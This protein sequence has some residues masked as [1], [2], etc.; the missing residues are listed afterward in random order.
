MKELKSILYYYNFYYKYIRE[1]TNIYNWTLLSSKTNKFGNE[2]RYIIKDE[3]I[4]FL[5]ERFNR[6]KFRIY[7]KYTKKYPIYFIKNREKR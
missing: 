3:M 4:Y 2:A 7:G 5:I 1:E 6:L